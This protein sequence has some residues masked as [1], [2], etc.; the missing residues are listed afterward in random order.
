MLC[1]C[2][3][4]LFISLTA[5]TEKKYL[6]FTDASIS[7]YNDIVLSD[8]DLYSCMAIC[9][10]NSCASIDYQPTVCAELTFEFVVYNLQHLNN[11]YYYLGQA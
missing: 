6:K 8:I 4:S 1:G 5:C 3:L 11:R 2:Y 7:G 9:E 10:D